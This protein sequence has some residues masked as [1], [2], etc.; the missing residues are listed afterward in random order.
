MSCGLTSAE[1]AA[2]ASGANRERVNNLMDALGLIND[3]LGQTDLYME[4]DDTCSSSDKNVKVN[5]V[6]LEMQVRFLKN[7][8]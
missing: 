1:R 2:A 7:I 4:N 6:G 5:M 8:L 3:C